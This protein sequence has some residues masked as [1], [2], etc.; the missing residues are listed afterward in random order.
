MKKEY[1]IIDE[2]IVDYHSLISSLAKKYNKK[3]FIYSDLYNSSKHNWISFLIGLRGTGKTVLFSQLANELKNFVYISLD[4]SRLKLFTLIEIIKYII[5]N[6]NPKFVFIDEINTYPEWY[7]ELKNIFDLFPKVKFFATGS[8]SVNILEGSIDLSRRMKIFY[9]PPLSFR[10]YLYLKHNIKIPPLTLNEILKE[11]MKYVDLLGYESKFIDYFKSALPFCLFDFDIKILSNLI[12]KII[13]SDLIRLRKINI[14]NVYEIYKILF[15]LTTSNEKINY[16]NMS[17]NLG[18]DKTQIIRY[19]KLL[20][21]ALLIK[22]ILPYGKGKVIL[23]KTPKIYI[24]VPFR[25]VFSRI[26]NIPIDIGALREDFFISHLY[27]YNI[28]YFATAPDFYVNGYTFEIGGKGK[29]RKVNPDFYVLQNV[30]PNKNIIPLILF[31]F[32]Y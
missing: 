19:I 21:N 22:R 26:L 32:L 31:G 24:T 12:S 18:I 8:S 29:S 7:K 14:E 16:S 3:R 13:E 17:K 10:E 4:D 9:L 15:F 27:H 25:Y 1:K 30:I 28:R 20:E 23:R 6:Y 5:G 2:V 11:P